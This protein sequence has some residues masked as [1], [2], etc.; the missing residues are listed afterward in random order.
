MQA[1]W[2]DE[3]WRGF[4]WWVRECGESSGGGEN[5]VDVEH[6]VVRIGYPF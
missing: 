2:P 3:R 5:G 6:Q 1:W 4:E